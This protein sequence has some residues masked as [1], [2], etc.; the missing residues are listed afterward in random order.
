MISVVNHGSRIALLSRK[1]LKLSSC[2]WSGGR[3]RMQKIL[4][5]TAE[6]LVLSTQANIEA[7]EWLLT[8]HNFTYVLPGVFADEALE[9]FFGQARQYN[10]GNFYIEIVDIKVTAETKNLHALLKYEPMLHKSNNVLCPSNIRIDDYYFDITIADTEDLV[11]SNDS[12]KQN[13]FSSW[14]FGT[15]SSR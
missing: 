1:L 11:Q 5:Q 4:K 2:A 14:I 9:K 13:Y 8:Q 10:G 7:A 12:I 6:A 3:G 15:Q